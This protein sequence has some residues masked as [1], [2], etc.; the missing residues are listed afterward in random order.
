MEELVSSAGRM[1][2]GDGIDKLIR[3]AE[4]GIKPATDAAA[5]PAEKTKK[6]KSMRMVYADGD[7]SLRR[8]WPRCLGMPSPQRRLEG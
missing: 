3:M 2:E 7:F 8:R 4:A 6:E 1:G 5:A